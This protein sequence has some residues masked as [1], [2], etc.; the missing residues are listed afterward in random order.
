MAQ[1]ISHA[2]QRIRQTGSQFVLPAGSERE[3]RLRAVLHVLY[4]VFNEGYTA[5][6]GT[7]L[8]RGE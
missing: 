3:E 6:S 7:A 1:R 4:L 5:S 2:K 8:R